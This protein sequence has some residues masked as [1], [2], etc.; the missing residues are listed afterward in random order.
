MNAAQCHRCRKVIRSVYR[1][2]F[3][4]CHCGDVSVDG[5]EAYNRRAFQT[6]ATWDEITTQEQYDNAINSQIKSVED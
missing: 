4:T 5:G 2:D 3:V 6:D 1:H